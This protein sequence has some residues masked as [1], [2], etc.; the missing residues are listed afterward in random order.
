MS[1]ERPSIKQPPQGQENAG[2]KTQQEKVFSP[3]DTERIN[4]VLNVPPQ[5]VE[6]SVENPADAESK[7]DSQTGVEEWQR[8]KQDTLNF[9]VG[10]IEQLPYALKVLKMV[11][12]GDTE[13]IAKYDAQRQ[14]LL[15]A[16]VPASLMTPEEKQVYYDATSRKR[17]FAGFLRDQYGIEKDAAEAIY[18]ELITRSREQD[19]K[20]KKE[21]TATTASVAENA[22][23]ATREQQ[24]AEQE[25]RMRETD[26]KKLEQVRKDLS[27]GQKTAGPIKSGDEYGI[28]EFFSGGL[29]ESY[30]K[31]A[32]E[33]AHRVAAAEAGTPIKHG[34]TEQKELN[35]LR[36][37]SVAFKEGFFGDKK[38][39]LEQE[40]QLK[41]LKMPELLELFRKDKD[42]KLL[43]NEALIEK[44]KWAAASAPLAPDGVRDFRNTQQFDVKVDSGGNI[45][46]STEQR[47]PHE[48]FAY[49]LPIL[50]LAFF[51]ESEDGDR[52]FTTLPYL[53]GGK[54]KKIVAKGLLILNAEQRKQLKEA[55]VARLGNVV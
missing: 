14:K 11:K 55:I 39:M 18:N 36:R 8:Y 50:S 40:K 48:R 45:L 43:K 21:S 28:K 35:F 17:G 13:I 41:D 4:W 23:K 24:K 10:K 38:K 31:P 37:E 53:V 5:T 47:F 29:R 46:F 52:K 19:A 44:Y 6:E 54:D 33:F 16:G 26:Q 34:D 12:S 15:A 42:G 49:D 22:E 7:Q 2:E 25:K 9:A 3:Q 27:I 30:L 32:I 51:A 20:L 1:L